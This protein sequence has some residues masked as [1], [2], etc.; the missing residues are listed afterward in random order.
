MGTKYYVA[1]RPQINENHAVHKE[2][3]PF[4]PDDNK[5]IYLGEFSSG[6]DAVREGQRHFIRTKGCVFCSKEH[7]VYEEELSPFKWADDL[8]PAEPEGPVSYLQSLIC[9][10]N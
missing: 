8:I 5:R 10:I 7:K 4:L 2:G 3:C 9:C 6:K 1:V